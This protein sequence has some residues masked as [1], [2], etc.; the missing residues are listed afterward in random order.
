VIKHGFFC[1]VSRIYLGRT[2]AET[3]D[4]SRV[5]KNLYEVIDPICRGKG[6]LPFLIGGFCNSG[7]EEG[8]AICP[9]PIELR[10]APNWC[11]THNDMCVLRNAEFAGKMDW[12]IEWIV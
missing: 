11:W 3:T 12:G 2:Y 5:R 6:R 4:N 9:A 1:I 8:L 7:G 10:L